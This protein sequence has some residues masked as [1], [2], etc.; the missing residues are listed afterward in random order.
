MSNGRIQLFATTMIILMGIFPTW[1][2][3][4]RITAFCGSASEAPLEEATAIF[5]ARTGID[6]DLVWGGSGS[7]LSQLKLARRGEL[8]IPGSPDFMDRA[9]A[10]GLV[11][12]RTKVILAYL[13]PAICVQK[14]N[15]KGIRSLPDL[16]RPGLRLAFGAPES[17]CVGLYG[18]EVIEAAGLLDSV[19]R[20][21]VTH[22]SSCSATASLVVM[23]KVDAVMGWDVFGSWNPAAVDV[24]PLGPGEIR[25]IAYIPAAVTSSYCRDRDSALAFLAFLS[26]E[27][28]RGIFRKWGYLSTEAEARAR[29]PDARI[30]GS[31][32]IPSGYSPKGGR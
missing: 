27:E 11:D 31:Y 19:E 28:V 9:E 12:P 30:G 1:A 10:E 15:P 26:S 5:R 14:G 16:G 23:K 17:V 2:E 32:A 21:V 29:A 22:A 18:L 20:N 3:S 7:V 24:V 4:R 25:R 6:V 8:Y 13:L